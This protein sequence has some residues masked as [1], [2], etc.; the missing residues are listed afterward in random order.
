MDPVTLADYRRGVL[1]AGLRAALARGDAQPLLLPACLVPSYVLPTVF[2]A[3]AGK[4]TALRPLRYPLAA[5]IAAA[6]MSQMVN[7]GGNGSGSGSG[8]A[9]SSSLNFASAYGKGLV[10]AWGT[11][12]ALVVLVWMDPWTAER[13]AQRRRRKS[14][15]G[16]TAAAIGGDTL[17]VDEDVTRS[18]RQGHEYYWQAFPASGS[19][20]ARLNWSLDL[21]LA[22]RGVGR[23]CRSRLHGIRFS[24]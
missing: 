1:R 11:L 2:L 4:H 18:L 9:P 8:D 13:V 24:Y 21:C 16:E 12:W 20:W 19:L 7:Q 15:A 17:V 14:M 6:N 23:L 10:F 5:A 3:V 22:W